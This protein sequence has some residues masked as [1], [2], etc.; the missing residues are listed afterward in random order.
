VAAA[1]SASPA[2]EAQ[3]T[4]SAAAR[5]LA[6]LASKPV[7]AGVVRHTF[8]RARA[9]LVALELPLSVGDRIHVRGATSDFLAEVASLRVGGSEVARAE[10]GEASLALPARAR[11]GDVIYALRAPA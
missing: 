7:R 2:P 10:A 3:S 8:N 11:A 5:E 9:A 1:A 6:V 4:A